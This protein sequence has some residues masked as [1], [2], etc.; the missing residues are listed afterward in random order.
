MSGLPD[1]ATD[2]EIMAYVYGDNAEILEDAAGKKGSIIFADCLTSDGTAQG[3]EMNLSS[4]LDQMGY[5]CVSKA[6]FMGQEQ[7]YYDLL[8]NIYG[9]DWDEREKLKNAHILNELSIRQERVKAKEKAIAELQYERDLIFNDVLAVFKNDIVYSEMNIFRGLQTDFL[10]RAWLFNEKELKEQVKEGK[11]TK[12]ELKQRKNEY[13]FAINT[14]MNAFFEEEFQEKVKF[15]K[16]I[17]EWT[18]GYAFYFEYKDQEISIYIPTFGAIDEKSYSH[19]ISGYR[20][21]YKESEYCYNF[22]CSNLEPKKVKERLNE[23]LLAEMWK[24]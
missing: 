23:W 11:L 16:I 14:V 10:R 17:Q 12:E 13:N 20:V 6:D 18:V 3:A 5:E 24:K 19:M 15:T 2:E 7:Q 21:N 22:I 8:E 4:I 9:I 1:D